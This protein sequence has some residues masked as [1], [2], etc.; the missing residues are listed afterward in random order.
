MAYRSRKPYIPI[1]RSG[2]SILASLMTQAIDDK[3]RRRYARI[4]LKVAQHQISPF[5]GVLM[6]HPM[7]VFWACADLYL[8]FY[9]LTIR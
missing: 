4:D 8:F 2:S 1:T 9:W 5:I 3:R 6:K 7:L